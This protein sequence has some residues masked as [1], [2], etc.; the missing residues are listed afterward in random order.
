[1]EAAPPPDEAE[2]SRTVVAPLSPRVID[3]VVSPPVGDV[4]PEE[5]VALAL[6]EEV[7]LVELVG[8]ESEPETTP[9]SPASSDSDSPLEAN[10]GMHPGPTLSQGFII[11][12]VMSTAILVAFMIN[13]IPHVVL[14]SNVK[15]AV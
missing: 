13:S 14:P 12:M 1:M 3:P 2:G 5:I 9:D 15:T 8:S 11:A 6:D 10:N 4:E 7:G